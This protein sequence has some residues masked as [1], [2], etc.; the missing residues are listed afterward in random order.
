MKVVVHKKDHDFKMRVKGKS[1]E[2]TIMEDS[3]VVIEAIHPAHIKIGDVV[4]FKVA[5]KIIIH[6]VIGI[7]KIKEDLFFVEKGDNSLILS[8]F[9]YESLLGRI[10]G[11]DNKN[12]L[13]LYDK[14]VV[15]N[16]LLFTY[17]LFKKFRPVK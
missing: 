2:P 4:V 16:Y 1:M 17:S 11:V 10:R 14:N 3:Y 7:H 12:V 9:P 5:N 6:R 15:E 8:I 13:K